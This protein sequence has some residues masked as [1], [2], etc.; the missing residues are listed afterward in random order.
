MARPWTRREHSGELN[1]GGAQQTPEEV[2][3]G[4][5]SHWRDKP[6]PTTNGNEGRQPVEEAIRRKTVPRNVVGVMD[7]V[8]VVDI[9]VTP[10]LNSRET[11]AHA[12]A[13]AALNESLA[14]IG[15]LHPVA[16]ERIV[17]REPSTTRSSQATGGSSPSSNWDGRRSPQ[18]SSTTSTPSSAL[19]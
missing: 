2:A 6:R 17:Y 8:N 16:V 3:P 10:R 11:H 18:W 9:L 12:L 13:N 7:E 4:S 19:R 5:S 14:S 1:Q 15:L